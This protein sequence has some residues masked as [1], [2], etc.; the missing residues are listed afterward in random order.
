MQFGK[1]NFINQDKL[2]R[3]QV[4]AGEGAT[5]EDVARE[6]LIMA[7]L[8]TDL[9]GE[10]ITKVKGMKDD[11]KKKERTLDQMSKK[12]LKL[13]AKSKKIKL[14]SKIKNEEIIELIEA[15]DKKNK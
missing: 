6:Y 9:K 12:E 10:R 15:F 1:Y 7:G 2:R 5:V 11:D 4:K 8:L 3:A 14:K 13:I